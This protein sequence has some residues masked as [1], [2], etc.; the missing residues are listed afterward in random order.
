MFGEMLGIWA[1]NFFQKI[2]PQSFE[3]GQQTQ[4]K[5]KS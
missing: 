4:A 1:V 2:A 5:N 3:Q